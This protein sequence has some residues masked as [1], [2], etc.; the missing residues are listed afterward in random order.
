MTYGIISDETREHIEE[1]AA[2][3]NLFGVI[4]LETVH[5]DEC[6][7]YL[8]DDITGESCACDC[9]D[10]PVYS[11]SI[12]VNGA[13]DEEFDIRARGY[14]SNVADWVAEL[15]RETLD[16]V[17]WEVLISDSEGNTVCRVSG[18]D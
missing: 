11:L 9:S 10:E 16:T 14:H 3:S 17:F 5:S 13:L 8:S 2:E 6:A 15:L 4:R 7:S 12:I 1:R 18:E